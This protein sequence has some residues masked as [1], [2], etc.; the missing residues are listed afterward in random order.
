MQHSMRPT[1]TL[2]DHSIEKIGLTLSRPGLRGIGVEA[3]TQQ[4]DKSG[5]GKARKNWRATWMD[6]VL[7]SGVLMSV[8]VSQAPAQNAAQ[9]AALARLGPRTASTT[10]TSGT[11]ATNIGL[12]RPGGLAFDAAGNLFIA[13]TDDNVV[14]EVAL[15]GTITVVAG[16][17]NQGYSGDGGAA[18]SAELDAPV[19]VAVDGSGNIYIA[20]THNQRIREVVAGTINTI[21]GTGVAGFSGDGSAATAAQLNRPTA[22]ALDSKG[23]IYIA[24]TNNHRIREIVGGTI[25]TVAGDGDETF[26]GDGGPA[27][28]AGLD[29]PDGVGVDS[30][31]N[32]YIGDTLNQ[33]VRMVTAATGIITTIAGTGVKTFT[34][35]GTATGAALARPRGI[36]VDSTGNIYVADSDNN[37]IRMIAN[38]SISTVAGD[39]LEGFNGDTG[40]SSSASLDAPRAVAAFASSV[41][42]ADTGN[43]RVRSSSGGTLNTIAGNAPQGAEQLLLS[44]PLSTVYGSGTLTATFSNNGLTGTGTVS[45]YDGQGSAGALLGTAALQSNSASLDTS[46]LTG[47]THSLI[48]VY[49]GDANAASITSG[50][51]VLVVNKAPVTATLTASA[52]SIAYG[53]PFTLTA[54]IASAVAGTPTGTVNFYSGTTLLNSTPVSLTNG[55]ATFNTTTPPLGSTNFTAVYTGDVDF[56]GATT[57]AVPITVI[58]PDFTLTGTPASQSLLPSHS[59]AYSITVTPQNGNF[60]FPVTLAASGLPSGVTAS[61]NPSSIAAGSGATTTTLT[62]SASNTAQLQKPASLT[63]LGGAVLALMLL[64]LAFT[65]QMR[66]AARAFEVLVLLLGLAALGTLAGC[67]GGGFYS[68]SAST[69]NV[70][71]TATSG[72]QTHITNVTVTLQ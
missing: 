19:G 24:D 52:S 46:H 4:R 56:A 3:V 10:S 22:I 34:A 30:S 49:S 67:G 16:D 58:S 39:G 72:P 26:S 9:K 12:D 33:R 48:A 17:G 14:R 63:K 15:D 53:V 25:S 60:I 50:V 11:E 70:T 45:F 51:Y 47:G 55:T 44:G 54:T 7:L 71:V 5:M 69:Y 62:L 28:A 13:D 36:A 6:R 59:V 1:H 65:R 23:N 42:F 61:F 35:D 37:R 20:D 32:I 31:F 29:S 41:A 40:N 66:R 2:N 8:A 18:T 64:P 21:A 57:S 38:N 68:K 27:I 43:D